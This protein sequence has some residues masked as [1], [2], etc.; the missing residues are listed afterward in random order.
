MEA[1]KECET[2]TFD[3][4]EIRDQAMKFSEEEFRKNIIEFIKE[5]Y[6]KMEAL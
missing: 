1:I 3:R 6:S 5:K 2:V 4:K